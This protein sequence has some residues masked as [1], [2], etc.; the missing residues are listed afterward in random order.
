MIWLDSHVLI[1]IHLYI[2]AIKGSQLELM[3]LNSIL[4]LA[5]VLD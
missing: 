4:I 2:S 5:A 1:V 3:N